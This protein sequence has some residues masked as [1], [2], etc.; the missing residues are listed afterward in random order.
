MCGIG[1]NQHLRHYTAHNF[2]HKFVDK[3]NQE[4]TTVL[5]LLYRYVYMTS[6]CHIEQ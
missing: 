4:W 5:N 6:S 2:T 3:A 1:A